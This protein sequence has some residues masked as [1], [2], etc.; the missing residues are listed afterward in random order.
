MVT[1]TQTRFSEW[2]QTGRAE[3]MERGHKPRALQALEKIP[4]IAGD[5]FLDIGCGNGWAACWLA[6]RFGRGTRVLGIDFSPD[7]I[8]L[9]QTKA[10]A[11]GHENVRFESC[12]FNHI[13]AEDRSFDHIFSMEALY[14]STDVTATLEEWYRVLKPGGTL[15]ACIDFYRENT[16][17]HGWPEMLGVPMALHAEAE[18]KEMLNRAGFDPVTSW[19]CL[20]LANDDPDPE[21]RAFNHEVGTLALHGVR[22]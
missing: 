12:D 3:G 18:W 1:V 11:I 9:A 7:M 16:Q 22:R 21:T 14:Y 15:T 8:A 4:A 17:S 19:R 5:T 20:D 6:D 2:A 13:P 10:S